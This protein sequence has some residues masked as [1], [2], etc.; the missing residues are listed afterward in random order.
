MGRE[1]IGSGRKRGRFK[2]ERKKGGEEQG[3]MKRV[4]SRWEEF[5]LVEECAKEKEGR[6]M[7][8]GRKSD[9]G[10]EGTWEQVGRRRKM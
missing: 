6:S 8:E 4:G 5:R 7:D 10:R 3:T 9:C 1:W 2:K